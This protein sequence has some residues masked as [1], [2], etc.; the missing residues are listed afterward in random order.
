MSRAY[1]TDLRERV[2]AAVSAGASARSAAA[3]FGIG[4]AT[5]VRWVRRWRDTGERTARRQGNP[6]RSA[7]EAH[8]A[9]LLGLLDGQVDITLDEMRAR[10]EEE[11]GHRAART[12]I[13]RFFAR[14]GFTVK[15][16]PV[17]RASRSEPTSRRRGSPGSPA[18]RSSTPSA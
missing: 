9:F 3:G 18:S 2:I 1:S 16:R 11:R 7:L 14:R 10:L 17:T 5:A 6:K 13:W 8:E 12:T 15:K 4:I